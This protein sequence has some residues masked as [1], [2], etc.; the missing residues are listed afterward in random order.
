MPTAIATHA[1]IAAA[2][3]RLASKDCGTLRVVESLALQ[4]SGESFQTVLEKFEWRRQSARGVDDESMLLVYLL[5]IALKQQKLD[6]AEARG[7][8]AAA[9]PMGLVERVKREEP[10]RYVRSMAARP[11]FDLEKYLAAYVDDEAKRERLRGIAA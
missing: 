1:E 11:G 9:A 10:E 4:L 7:Q 2:V 8:A 5:K 6:E 3:A